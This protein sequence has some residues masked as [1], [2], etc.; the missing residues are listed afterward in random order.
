MSVGFLRVLTL[1]VLLCPALSAIAEGGDTQAP[2]AAQ[3]VRAPATAPLKATPEQEASAHSRAAERKL[4]IE[5][6]KEAQQVVRELSERLAGLSDP[7]ARRAI[8]RQAVEVKREARLQFLRTKASFARERGEFEIA[9]QMEHLIER[10]LRP[11]F[12][13]PVTQP[14]KDKGAA[15]KDGQP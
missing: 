3:A 6:R 15:R 9:D 8:E 12:S 10:T 14:T 1:V 7:V 4:L 13:A 11:R 2:L 5:Q